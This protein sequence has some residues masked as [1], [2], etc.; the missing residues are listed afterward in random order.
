MEFHALSRPPSGIG[1]Y[2]FSGLTVDM[3]GRFPEEFI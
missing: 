2:I 1:G 3:A